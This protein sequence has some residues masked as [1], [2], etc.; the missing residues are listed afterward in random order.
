MGQPSS[1]AQNP[2]SPTTEVV[3]E[4]S[5]SDPVRSLDRS[6]LK[7]LPGV[8]QLSSSIE[9]VLSTA[10]GDP[11]RSL[12]IEVISEYSPSDPF[13]SLHRSNLRV[14]LGVTQLGHSIEVI[15][16]YSRG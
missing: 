1:L 9:M 15:S 14:H 11:V 8:T 3:S 7:V 5:Q 4:Y 13:R 12:A 2:H 6:S 16:E 10:G